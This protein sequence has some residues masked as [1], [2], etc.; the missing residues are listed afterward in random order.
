MLGKKQNCFNIDRQEQNFKD[1]ILLKKKSVFFEYTP[2][3]DFQTV[4]DHA[5]IDNGSQ[6]YAPLSC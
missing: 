3:Q 1:R 2:C 4:L 6:T 5:L